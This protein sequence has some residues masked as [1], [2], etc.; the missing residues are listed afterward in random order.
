MGITKLLWRELA[1]RLIGKASGSES[2]P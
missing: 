2:E 1:L